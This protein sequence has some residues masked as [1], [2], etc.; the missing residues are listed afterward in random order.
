M[1][2]ESLKTIGYRF[3]TL[4]Y[5]QLLGSMPRPGGIHIY[6]KGRMLHNFNTYITATGYRLE[7]STGVP[8][9]SYAMGYREDG[10][11]RN[12]RGELEAYNFGTIERCIKEVSRVIASE[13]GGKVH[14]G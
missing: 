14:N 5:V 11:K 9:S 1:E 4:L 10:S 3:A 12:P 8:Y 7:M 13:N 2:G 6:S